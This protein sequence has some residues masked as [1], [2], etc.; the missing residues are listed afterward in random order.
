MARIMQDNFL[1]CLLYHILGMLHFWT[2]A[3]LTRGHTNRSLVHVL[4]PLTLPARYWG[5]AS[6][7][8]IPNTADILPLLWT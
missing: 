4:G 7:L 3:S 1:V 6:D 8:S 2:A 5:H